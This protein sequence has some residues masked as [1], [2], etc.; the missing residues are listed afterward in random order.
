VKIL[1]IASNELM[2]QETERSLATL[3]AEIRITAEPKVMLRRSDRT[4]RETIREQ[5]AEADIVF[6]GLDV[7]EDETRFGDYAARLMELGEPLRT[8]FYVK[9]ASLFVGGLVESS[10]SAEPEPE[11]DEA[12][13]KREAPREEGEPAPR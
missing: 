3:L 10:D 6:L 13:E 1:S 4:V 7:P 5:S 2:K 12:D 9:N 11:P 8:V